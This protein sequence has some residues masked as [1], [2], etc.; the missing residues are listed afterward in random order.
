MI[1]PRNDQDYDTFMYGTE[2]LPGDRTWVRRSSVVEKLK[3]LIKQ[4]IALVTILV[5]KAH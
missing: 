1:D 4:F 3:Q 2:P 5:N